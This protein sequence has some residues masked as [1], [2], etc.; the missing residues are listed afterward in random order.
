[1]HP[2]IHATGDRDDASLG[3]WVGAGL[4]P[5]EQSTGPRGRTHP[6]AGRGGLRT[7]S[8]PG[9]KLAI[10]SLHRVDDRTL[11][12][13]VTLTNAGSKPFSFNGSWRE[14]G[15]GD[16]FVD[17]DLGGATL[18]DPAAR[19]RY[20]V[21]RDADRRCLCSTNLGQG[22]IGN[23]GLSMGPGDVMTFFGYF[24]APDAATK[25][26]QVS[27]PQYTPTAVDIS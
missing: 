27:L 25:T 18:F 15:Y 12:L 7:G 22:G 4:L 5:A 9:V 16:P 26:L 6:V 14:P 23:D 17:R 19:K 3:W 10:N 20:L 24:P 21:L 2:L 13:T 8:V 11:L 1:M